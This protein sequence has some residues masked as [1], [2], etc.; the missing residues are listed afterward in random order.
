MKRG[1]HT[2][3]AA[4]YQTAS[5]ESSNARKQRC[6]CM[7]PAQQTQRRRPNHN[8][9][10]PQAQSRCNHCTATRCQ[11]ITMGRAPPP[12]PHAHMLCPPVTN[13]YLRQQGFGRTPRGTQRLPTTIEA[14]QRR[15]TIRGEER[16]VAGATARTNRV[17]KC[18]STGDAT[19]NP[20]AWPVS[21][22]CAMHNRAQGSGPNKR[23]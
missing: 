2:S 4:T 15:A 8:H 1:F 11:Q 20:A 9:P 18:R 16:P 6:L 17:H 5:V 14:A 23:R 7:Q 3:S 22:P 21:R 10:K 19:C 13:V 12:P